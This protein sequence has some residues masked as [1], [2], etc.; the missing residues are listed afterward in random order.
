MA[1]TYAILILTYLKEKLYE[2]KGKKFN[3]NLNHN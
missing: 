2:I 1:P 3:N